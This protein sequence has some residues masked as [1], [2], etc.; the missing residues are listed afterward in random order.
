M[1]IQMTPCMVGQGEALDGTALPSEES[2]V[3]EDVPCICG[4]CRLYNS[5]D[6]YYCTCS[7]FMTIAVS[8]PS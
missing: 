7:V 4:A 8:Q 2:D 5:L 3:D 1:K 6:V